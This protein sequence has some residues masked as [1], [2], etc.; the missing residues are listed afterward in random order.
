MFAGLTFERSPGLAIETCHLCHCRQ[1]VGEGASFGR[2]RCTVGGDWGVLNLGLCSCQMTPDPVGD[3][4]LGA[5]TLGRWRFR[6]RHGSLLPQAG[7]IAAECPVQGHDTALPRALRCGVLIAQCVV[8]L[9]DDQFVEH[10]A[11]A[12]DHGLDGVARL[13]RQDCLRGGAGA[14]VL[15]L[16]GFA[17][18]FADGLGGLAGDVGDEVLVTVGRLRVHECGTLGWVGQ[19]Q[20][21]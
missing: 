19:R 14:L 5:V 7:E 13:E 16:S 1:G 9:S 18:S 2:L 4:G 15:V 21:I 8:D 20:L 3:I 10:H 11:V 17:G 12:G 6:L